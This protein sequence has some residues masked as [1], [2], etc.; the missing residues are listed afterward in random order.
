[1]KRFVFFALITLTFHCYAADLQE[2]V[3]RALAK[4]IPQS[5]KIIQVETP[6]YKETDAA[7][8]FSSYLKNIIEISLTEQQKEE[9]DLKANF[10]NEAFIA[11]LNESGY[12]NPKA[13]S[14]VE[15]KM[16]D[17]QL[18][19]E[20]IEKKNSVQISFLYRQFVGNSKRSQCTVST[21]NLPGLTYQPENLELAKQ[22]Y[23]DVQNSQSVAKRTPEKSITIMA[24]MLDS[25]NNMVDVLY[26]DSQV[27]FIIGSPE[28]NAYIAI[29]N[30]SA[31]G[32]K[33]WLKDKKGSATN[34]IPAG[35]TWKS[36][37][38]HPVDN[39]YG[40][41]TIYIY[42]A[43]SPEGLP[44]ADSS[45]QYLPD[46]ITSITRELMADLSTDEI[47][48]GNFALS[49]TVLPTPVE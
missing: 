11:E 35:E 29:L 14:W 18:R 31:Q 2:E 48:T 15:R 33:V 49:Y 12:K 8:Q 21:K 1:M 28:K 9:F 13:S 36:D 4:I 40:T 20:F 7:S 17:G 37:Y 46:T 6:V 10:E 43:S 3:A 38:F 19:T 26:P 16:P 45:K 5:D 41:E 25:E 22:L 47:A 24:V 39:V 23:S 27:H 30:I 44:T 32:K 42:A 34:F